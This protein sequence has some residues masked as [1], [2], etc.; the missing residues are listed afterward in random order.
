MLRVPEP[1]ASDR[2]VRGTLES[3]VEGRHTF[4]STLDANFNAGLDD[5][6]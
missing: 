5:G 3:F 4:V 6:Y 2:P 1:Q